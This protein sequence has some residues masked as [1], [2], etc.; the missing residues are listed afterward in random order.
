MI[1][2]RFNNHQ[3]NLSFAYLEKEMFELIE[4]KR[5]KKIEWSIE[6]FIKSTM[7]L[8]QKTF[9]LKIKLMLGLSGSIFVYF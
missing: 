6:E 8:D 2:F 4:N 7:I 9:P 5:E 1:K 3:I